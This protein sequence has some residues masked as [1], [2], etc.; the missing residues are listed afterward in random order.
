MK[1]ALKTIQRYWTWKRNQSNLSSYQCMIKIIWNPC[2]PTCFNP[3]LQWSLNHIQNI[4]PECPYRSRCRSRYCCRLSLRRLALCCNMPCHMLSFRLQICNC[5]NQHST[6]TSDWSN[7][8]SIQSNNRIVIRSVS[9]QQLMRDIPTIVYSMTRVNET[10]ITT[11]FQCLLRYHYTS[12]DHF[13]TL[14]HRSFSLLVY[15]DGEA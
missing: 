15:S 9:C 1:S 8:I 13:L 10:Y 5:S 4:N 3:S 2:H 7:A 12:I 6:T 11:H 14:R